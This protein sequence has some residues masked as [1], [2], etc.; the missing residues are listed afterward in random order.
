MQD[1]PQKRKPDISTA[2]REIHWTPQVLILCEI[3]PPN[4]ANRCKPHVMYY[5]LGSAVGIRVA[6]PAMA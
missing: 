3:I 1:D 4:Y 2:K 5:F 6:H